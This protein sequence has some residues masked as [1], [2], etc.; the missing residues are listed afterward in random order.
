MNSFTPIKF[1]RNEKS[2]YNYY[3][4]YS[5]KNQRNVHV[6]SQQAYYHCLELEL[7]ADIKSYCENPEQ[8]NIDN[9]N[10]IYSKKIDFVVR[11]NNNRYILQRLLPYYDINITNK[12]KNICISENI[13]C[14]SNNYDYQVILL[15]FKYRN[16]YY[17]HNVKILYGLLKHTNEPLY[18][19][20]LQDI[21]HMIHYTKNN[22]I[23]TLMDKLNLSQ[24]DILKSVAIGVARGIILQ[25]SD[26]SLITINTEVKL[27]HNEESN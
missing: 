8:I 16:N 11:S 19:R 9:D 2:K 20:T 23:K 12:L 7:N 17:F 6:Y 25:P 18:N 1:E 14:E 15:D 27:I 24:N 26:T 21:T 4:F 10:L 22:T 5:I 13:W 3:I